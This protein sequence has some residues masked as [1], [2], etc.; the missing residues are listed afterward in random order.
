MVDN[1]KDKFPGYFR[2][3][4]SRIIFEKLNWTVITSKYTCVS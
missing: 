2:Y 4:N 1:I 3:E